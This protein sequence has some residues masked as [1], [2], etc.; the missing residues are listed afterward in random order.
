MHFLRSVMSVPGALA[1]LK[2]VRTMAVPRGARAVNGAGSAE[3]DVAAAMRNKA[4]VACTEM[5]VSITVVGWRSSERG[6]CRCFRPAPGQDPAACV[7]VN[8]GKTARR[9]LGL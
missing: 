7:D 8:E 9:A 1:T 6:R 5:A 3:A 4:T 2:G